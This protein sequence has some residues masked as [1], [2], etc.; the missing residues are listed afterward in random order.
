MLSAFGNL[1]N[2]LFLLGAKDCLRSDF[3]AFQS[4][5]E[6]KTAA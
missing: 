1:L 4:A 5:S 3:L 2:T 6:S